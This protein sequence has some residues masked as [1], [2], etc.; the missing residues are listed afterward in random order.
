MCY[1]YTRVKITQIRRCK[2]LRCPVDLTS[3]YQAEIESPWKRVMN[4]V[5]TTCKKG[6]KIPGRGF[7]ELARIGLSNGPVIVYYSVLIIGFHAGT[8]PG[9][10][11]TCIFSAHNGNAN[12]FYIQKN[13]VIKRLTRCQTRKSIWQSVATL[14]LNPH[15]D[16][17]RRTGP[18]R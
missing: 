17:N 8:Y 3:V 1:L 18:P 13:F 12:P 6:G 16:F 15:T 7:L 5:W 14:F 4:V 11:G 2:H 9:F 10:L